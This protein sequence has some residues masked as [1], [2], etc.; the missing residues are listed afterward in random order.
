M[1]DVVAHLGTT[2]RTGVGKLLRAAVAARG[3][4]D[5]MELALAADRV[6]AYSTDELVA[7]LRLSAD[8]T[9]RLF[10]SGPMDPLMDVVIHAQ[11]IARPLGKPYV[12]PGDVVSACL[13]Y[14]ARNKLMG[15]PKRLAGVTVVSTDTGWRSG[16]GPELTGADE[17]LLLVAAGRAAGL[18][19]LVGPGRDVV[20]ARLA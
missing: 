17:D 2:T 5:R 18:S 15:G 19:G 13:T 12:S 3:S 20:A 8:S 14:V 6:A 11:D 10:L 7:Q 1:R 9:R 4:F 16:A